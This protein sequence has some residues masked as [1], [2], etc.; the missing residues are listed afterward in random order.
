MYKMC[1]PGILCSLQ[2][3]PAPNSPSDWTT[4]LS[5]AHVLSLPFLLCPGFFSTLSLFP[6]SFSIILRCLSYRRH[7]RR[8]PCQRHV[9][10]SDR[11]K[12]NID[13][14]FSYFFLCSDREMNLLFAQH[15]WGSAGVGGWGKPIYCTPSCIP[16]TPSLFQSCYNS[17]AAPPSLWL[18]SV[19]FMESS[20]FTCLLLCCINLQLNAV[21]L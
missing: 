12:K 5:T 21:S 1:I 7:I 10:V 2:M 6:F 8:L 9:P 3:H 19:P 13:R 14:A 4:S 20:Y 16:P 11:H 18:I 15:A 17:P